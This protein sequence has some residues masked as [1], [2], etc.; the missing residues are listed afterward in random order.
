MVWDKL[1]FSQQTM[2]D[3]GERF[4][5]DLRQSDST[6]FLALARTDVTP[7]DDFGVTACVMSIRY[8]E[9]LTSD[10]RGYF[11]QDFRPLP[12]RLRVGLGRRAAGPGPADASHP[13]HPWH[14]AFQTAY[15]ESDAVMANLLRC[16]I[17]NPFR[18]APAFDPDWRTSAVVGVAKQ[19]DETR[20]FGNLPVLADALQDAGCE[21]AAVLDH[22]R[23]THHHARGC[24]VLEQILDRT[25]PESP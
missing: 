20:T 19:I 1:T 16:I 9:V 21:V 25:R 8:L 18:P 7:F 2:I 10:Y 15:A 5:L 6:E 13:D 23:G 14:V 3:A 11:Q 12:D 22:C 4:F 17:G 24:W